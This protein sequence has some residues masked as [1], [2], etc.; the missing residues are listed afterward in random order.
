[1]RS[2]AVLLVVSL[3]LASCS[4][5]D[6]DSAESSDS[7]TSV[8]PE[9][10]T[11]ASTSAP[12]T[13]AET[14]TIASTTSVAPLTAPPQTIPRT[15]T[16]A[17][18]TTDARAEFEPE[19]AEVTCE[20]PVPE[21]AM[22]SR[23]DVP[24]KWDIPDT[25]QSELIS[26]PIVVLPAASGDENADAVVIPAG[27]PGGSATGGAERWTASELH[28][29]FDI[30]LYDQRGTGL[31]QPNLDCPER[32]AVF[33][34][35]LTRV[36][37]FEVERTALVEAMN[38]CRAR[39]EADGVDMND[40]DTE[41]SVR[42][43]DAIRAALGYERWNL[44]GIS[45][46]AR[47]SLA[48]MRSSPEGIR[49]VILDSVY[50]VTRGGLGATAE[51]AER[52][53]AELVGA[54]ALDE[55]CTAAHGDLGAL[56]DR[57][58]SATN[59]T[60]IE[61]DHDLG[62]GAGPRRFVITGDDLIGGLFSAM[63]DAAL[64][65]ILPGVIHALADGN[66]GIVPQFLDMGVPFATQFA[67]AMQ[68][69]VDCADNAELGEEADEAVIADPGRT[70]L[71]VASPLCRE[72]PVEPTSPEFNQPVTSDIP[73]LVLAG[74]FDP[75]TPPAGTE[76]VASRLRNSTFALWA[77]RG[78]GVTGEACAVRIVL[79]F[80]TDPAAELDLSCLQEVQAPDL[81]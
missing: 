30:V 23:I 43:L 56:L 37:P 9:T 60:P 46:G 26:L 29:Q 75:I 67:D 10:T 47:L 63:Y 58:V 11:P 59:E 2:L 77:D 18:V 21:R 6:D 36:E 70:A 34:A 45:Y 76:S 78:H 64:I 25:W 39:L 49:A 68:M 54:C 55:G 79:A 16:I 52:A 27:G 73:A 40:Y 80:L 19:A 74:R 66:T 48:A 13:V 33:V 35:N 31:A 3:G 5:G 44:L 62:D 42:D 20:V 61:L 53:V 14:T 12:T 41:A 22:C 4:G 81:G 32:D 38:V 15:T 7:T 8:A 51:S 17:P 50:D 65:P 71:L 28:G 57:V 72:W 24:A 1:M 69:S